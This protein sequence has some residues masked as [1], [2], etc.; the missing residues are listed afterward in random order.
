MMLLS[1]ALILAPAATAGAPPVAVKDA[2]AASAALD[3]ARLAIA[4][5]VVDL[6]LP[7]DR[8]EQ[9]FMQVID[10]ML[11]NMLAG[12]TK[13]IQLEESLRAYP[14]LR[15]ILGTFIKRQRDLVLAD[16]KESQPELLL[17]YANAYARTFDV[18]ELELIK[19]FLST[20]AGAKFAQRSVDMLRDPDVAA[21]QRATAERAQRREK[22]ELEKFKAELDEAIAEEEGKHGHS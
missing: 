9:M 20:R 4:R 5:D 12:I 19:A 21:W 18:A 14:K 2:P 13:G 17:A 3:P 15:T 22:A 8:R 11:S 6:V 7:P 16:L 10:T 1:F